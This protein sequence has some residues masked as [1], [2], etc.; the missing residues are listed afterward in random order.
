MKITRSIAACGVAG[1][2]VAAIVYGLLTWI[3]DPLLEDIESPLVPEKAV[4][5]RMSLGVATCR[6]GNL[7]RYIKEDSESIRAPNGAD[8]TFVC[9]PQPSHSR[10]PFYDSPMQSLPGSLSPMTL[11][12]SPTKRCGHCKITKAVAEFAVS[13]AARDG[14]GG[15]VI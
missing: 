9:G 12:T 1:S 7:P 10:A 6:S 14:R 13:K 8:R 15:Q 4:T 11:T 5:I 3:V 2:L